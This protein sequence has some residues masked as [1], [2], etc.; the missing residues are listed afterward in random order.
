MNRACILT[1]Q[2]AHG[3]VVGGK[4]TKMPFDM[5]EVGIR[6]SGATKTRVNCHLKG[7]GDV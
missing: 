2:G 4:K 6:F 3:Q 5:M 1:F 7:Q